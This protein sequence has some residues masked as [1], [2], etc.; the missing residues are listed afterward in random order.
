MYARQV[1]KS[2]AAVQER[3]VESGSVAAKRFDQALSPKA[4]PRG[5]SSKR[6]STARR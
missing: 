3:R 2:F 6:S 4:R 5:A 1:L